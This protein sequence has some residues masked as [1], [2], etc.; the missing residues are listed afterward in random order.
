MKKKLPAFL[1]CLCL[2]VQLAACDQTAPEGA[3]SLPPKGPPETGAPAE[4]DVPET[5]APTGAETPAPEES[6]PAVYPEPGTVPLSEILDREQQTLYREAQ[7]LYMHMFA[8]N[9]YEG[10]DNLPDGEELPETDP[11]KWEHDG[12]TYLEVRGYYAGW[13]T[14]DRDIH[15]CF[16][17]RWWNERNDI[18]NGI[19]IYIEHDGRLYALA[20]EMSGGNYNGDSF[21][22]TYRLLNRTEDTIEFAAIGHYSWRY[23]LEGETLEDRDH[24]LETSYDYT[25]EFLIR[26]VLTEDGWRFDQFSVPACVRDQNRVEMSYYSR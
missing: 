18:E 7:E 9:T 24:R 8:W 15:R 5:A 16:T 14:F 4:S 1:L 3:G 2:M 12:W 20:T 23:P 19:P 17:D 10:I 25:M 26:L 21:P 13:E 11:A 22:D 6:Q